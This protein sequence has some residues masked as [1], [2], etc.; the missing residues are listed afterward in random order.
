MYH[1]LVIVCFIVNRLNFSTLRLVYLL[2]HYGV[3]KFFSDFFCTFLS[4]QSIYSK[5]TNYDKEN[6][7]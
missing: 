4:C 2:Y 5:Q 6:L 3:L 1:F 7:S